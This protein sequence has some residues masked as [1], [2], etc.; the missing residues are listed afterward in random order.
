MALSRPWLRQLTAAPSRTRT[1]PARSTQLNYSCCLYTRSPPTSMA[2]Q[3]SPETT[4]K[5]LGPS[6]HPPAAPQDR[7]STSA[8][9]ETTTSNRPQCL[10]P[11]QTWPQTPKKLIQVTLEQ[12]RVLPE[13]PAQAT[14]LLKW[15]NYRP[16]SSVPTSRSSSP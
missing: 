4:R 9:L 8:V 14:L 5:R 2:N 6:L 12:A 1:L 10:A 7:S 11:R 16:R 15:A 13:K 3:R